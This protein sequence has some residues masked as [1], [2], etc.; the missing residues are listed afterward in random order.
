MMA[1]GY[2]ANDYR[3]RKGSNMV[4]EFWT[5]PMLVTECHSMVNRCIVADSAS[6]AHDRTYAMHDH[7]PFT[8]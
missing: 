6:R 7:K 8:D 3:A 1:N 2:L 5:S 4:A